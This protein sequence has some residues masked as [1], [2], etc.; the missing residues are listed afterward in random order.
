MRVGSRSRWV[1]L[2][3]AV[4]SAMISPS[5]LLFKDFRIDYQ[6]IYYMPFRL[7][8]LIRYGEGPHMSAWAL[9]PFSLAA[10]WIRLA[11]RPSRAACA[12]RRHRR[13]GGREQL[14][15]RHRARHLLPDPGVVRSGW[16]NRTGWSGCAPLASPRLP[17]GL[18]AF[19]LTP[20]YLRITL[21]NMKLVSQPG[22]LWSAVLGARGRRPSRRSPGGWRADGRSARGRVLARLAR[23]PVG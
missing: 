16:R 19:W 6:G 12:L 2:W 15:W 1:A 14:L 18:S 11:P 22:H 7:G 3:A 20:S 10:A 17:A 4:A 13:A 5:F 21:D 9:L 8:V 23:D